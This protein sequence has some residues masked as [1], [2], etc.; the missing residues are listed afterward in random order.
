[1]EAQLKHVYT[2][3]T[4]FCTFAVDLYAQLV[5]INKISASELSRKFIKS[6]LLVGYLLLPIDLRVTC[7]FLSLRWGFTTNTMLMVGTKSINSS[8]RTK[9]K[10]D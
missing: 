10:K 7:V 8:C 3:H 1:M 6:K 2:L 9:A 5:L 4:N